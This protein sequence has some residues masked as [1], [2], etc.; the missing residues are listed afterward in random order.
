MSSKKSIEEILGVSVYTVKTEFHDNTV[1]K[2]WFMA[3]INVNPTEE[4]ISNLGKT[5]KNMAYMV[6]EKISEKT[7]PDHPIIQKLKNHPIYK[8]IKEEIS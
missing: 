6:I 5:Y 2:D 4:I 3:R 7:N 1:K 8:K